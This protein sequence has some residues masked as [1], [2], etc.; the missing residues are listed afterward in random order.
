VNTHPAT[1]EPSMSTFKFG[2]FINKPENPMW[3][4]M[5]TGAHV[6][7]YEYARVKTSRQAETVK[8]RLLRYHP[9]L[10]VTID[11]R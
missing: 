4:V 6:P 2:G 3:S 11:Y 10:I 5:V 8:R 7:L 1:K 9:D